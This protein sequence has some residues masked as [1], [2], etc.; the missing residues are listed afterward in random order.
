[1]PGAAPANQP[2]GTLSNQRYADFDAVLVERV[3]H[4]PMLERPDVFNVKLAD[5]LA[6]IMAE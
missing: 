4:Y 1:M 3:G 6:D 2:T 5:V